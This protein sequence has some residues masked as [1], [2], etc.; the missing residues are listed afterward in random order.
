MSLLVWGIKESLIAYVTGM[1]DGAVETSDGARPGAAGFEFPGSDD[2]FR[3]CVTL[4]GHD[5]MMHVAIRD[6]A[7]VPEGSGWTLTV[8]DPDDP[9]I[10]LT[11]ARIAALEAGTDGV[12]RAVGTALTADGADLFFGPYVEGT[13]L[14]DPVIEP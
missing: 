4:S 6:P 5:G 2:V 11:F 10:R 1:P 9:G 12:R 14:D 3:G 7:L 13:P 8:A